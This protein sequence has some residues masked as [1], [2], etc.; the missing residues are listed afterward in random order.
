M[1]KIDLASLVPHDHLAQVLQ[2]D[3]EERLVTTSRVRGV[4]LRFLTQSQRQLWQAVGHEYIEPELLDFIDS[5]PRGG[6]YYDIGASTGIFACY[7]AAKG[8][9]VYAF[10]P[11]A[12]NFSLLDHNN[13]LNDGRMHC[14]NLALSDTR[15]LGKMYSAKFEAAGHMKIL[16]QPR[17]VAGGTFEPDHV[18]T[19]LKYPLDGWV[20]DFCAPR[21][22]YIKVDVDGAEYEVLLGA[23]NLLRDVRAI[24][25]ELYD[26]SPQAALVSGILD[27]LG[28]RLESRHQVQHYADLWNCVY[29][30]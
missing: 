20:A 24:F 3:R 19:V 15:G 13:Y 17:Y 25:I 1:E 10:E 7:A 14:F 11:E 23:K 16:D 12:Q 9:D 18:A 26:S 28:F 5:I 29:R 22:E 21:P 2:R 4:E 8:L 6:V 27:E 30:K